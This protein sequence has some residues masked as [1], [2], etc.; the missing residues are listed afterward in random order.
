MTIT[1]YLIE[2]TETYWVY[3]I[4]D[5]G[6]RVGEDTVPKGENEPYPDAVD[7]TGSA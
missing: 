3:E 1:R 5:D 4:R 7:E 6:E 2:E